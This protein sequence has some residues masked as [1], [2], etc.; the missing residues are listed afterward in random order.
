ML[1]CTPGLNFTITTPGRD[2]LVGLMAD[3]ALSR[4]PNWPLTPFASEKAC[5]L[6]TVIKMETAKNSLHETLL[7]F[8][9][10]LLLM[11]RI[12]NHATRISTN[13]RAVPVR[14]IQ[15]LIIFAG[16]R[17]RHHI[18]LVGCL[19]RNPDSDIDRINRTDIVI[20]VYINRSE[21]KIKSDKG[22]EV[23]LAFDVECYR[24]GLR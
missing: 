1:A 10:A 24:D 12:Y 17:Y 3:I 2:I 13:K 18:Q 21:A 22:P 15:P 20:G 23:I 19:D 8:N 14:P 9:L 16:C 4:E 11:K 7:K 6:L 5:A